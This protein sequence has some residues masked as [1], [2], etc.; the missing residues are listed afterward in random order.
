MALTLPTRPG[1]LRM[2]W[3]LRG[4]TSVSRSRLTRV[5]HAVRL[6][7]EVWYCEFSTPRIKDRGLRSEW[8]SFLLETE[9]Q[10]NVFE[11]APFFH[12]EPRASIGGT[13]VVD[14]AGQVG[15][16]VDLRGLAAGAIVN[17]GD[18]LRFATTKQLVMATTAGTADGAGD[19]ADLAIKPR[20]RTSPADGETVDFTPVV[21][22]TLESDDVGW[23][24]N[25]F[26]AFEFSFVAEELIT[27]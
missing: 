16:T 22:M 6:G 7:G 5:K 18:F 14:G 17:Q 12:G 11:V 27:A 8:M 19:L 21:E 3:G 13:P 1:K 24:V 23:D 25:E 2:R 9:G 4:N 20:L 10:A 26:G 15:S